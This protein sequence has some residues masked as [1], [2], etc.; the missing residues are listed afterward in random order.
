MKVLPC[1]NCEKEECGVHYWIDDEYYTFCSDKCNEE[2]KKNG[3]E[4]C[5]KNGEEDAT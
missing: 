4:T 1:L 2:H 3:S 5:Y